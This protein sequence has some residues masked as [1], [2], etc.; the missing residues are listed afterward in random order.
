MVLGAD[1]NRH[2]GKAQDQSSQREAHGGFSKERL[3]E[4]IPI[5]FAIDNHFETFYIGPSNDPPH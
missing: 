2:E 3:G 5:M 4:Y 1:E